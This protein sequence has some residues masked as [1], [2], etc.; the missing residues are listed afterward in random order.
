MLNKIQSNEISEVYQKA[1]QQNIIDEW[2]SAVIFYSYDILESRL[3]HLKDIFPENT[4]HAI[5]IKTNSM[6]DILK[7][8]AN[9]GFGLEA[10]SWEELLLAQKAG[11][12]SAKAVFDSPVKRKIEIDL[13][14]TEFENMILN[15]NS[16]EELEL[17]PHNPDYRVGLRINPLIKT[18]APGMFDVSTKRSKFGVPI[19]QSPEIINACLKYSFISGLHM[20]SGSEIS[21]LQ[22]N[23]D[24]I[25][26]LKK[27]ADDINFSR[28]QNNIDS[29][30]TFIDIGGGIPADYTANPQ[31]GLDTYVDKIKKTCPDIFSD[32]QVITEFGHYI[33]A[34]T[35]WVLSDIEYM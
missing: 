11:L 19:N 25:C 5:A 18:G 28:R 30:I 7:F 6:P 15:A 4:F 32:Y 33:H 22:N 3:N 12:D 17:I 14:A 27:L 20:H 2:D 10:A 16:F 34:N 1:F 24:A 23:V 31:P 9:K 35:S 8:I 21:A 26:A 29:Q 13:C